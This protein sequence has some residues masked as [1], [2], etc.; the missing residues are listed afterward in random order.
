MREYLTPAGAGAAA[1]IATARAAV[2]GAKVPTTTV[3][4]G[5]LLRPEFLLEAVPTAIMSDTDV[6]DAGVTAP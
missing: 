6:P 5:T 1:T 2:L 3:G 4:C